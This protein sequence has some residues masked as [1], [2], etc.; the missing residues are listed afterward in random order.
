MTSSANQPRLSS[1]IVGPM[2]THFRTWKNVFL[3]AIAIS[4]L[5]AGSIHA[6]EPVKKF[7]ARL[8][9]EGLSETGIKYLDLCAARDRLPASMKGDLPLERNILLQDSIKNAKTPQQRDERIAAIEQGYKQFLDASPTHPRRSEAQTKLGD[10]LLERAQTFL[11]DSKKDEN[12]ESA[13]T[14]RSKARDVYT[15]AMG[16]YAKIIEELK[17]ILE[18][19]KGDKIKASD[20]EGKER[21]EQYQKDYR[22]AQILNAKMMEFMSQ[23]YDPQS[24]DWRKWL[25]NS[26]AALSQII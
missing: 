2:K 20:T 3:I 11:S 1:L 16:L 6:E 25:E 7:L 8:R 19:M 9:D 17:P 5:F 14:L 26:E 18:S 21:R 12:K 4:F 24:A 10:L 15:E 22:G 23:T 13:T